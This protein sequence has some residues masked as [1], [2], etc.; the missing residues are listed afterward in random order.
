MTASDD[1]HI[2]LIT[3]TVAIVVARGV[4]LVVPIGFDDLIHHKRL[5]HWAFEVTGYETVCIHIQIFFLVLCFF[6][7]KI[8]F[9]FCNTK[10][11]KQ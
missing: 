3:I 5:R 8:T 7:P 9:C 2:D 4:Y 11:P 1:D 6:L 10:Y